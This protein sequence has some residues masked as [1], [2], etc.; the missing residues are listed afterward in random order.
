MM[1]PNTWFKC[2]VAAMRTGD[3]E[4]AITCFSTLLRLNPEFGE[5]WSNLAGVLMKVGKMR[6]AFE[7]ARQSIRFLR[8]NWRVWD[9]YVTI[10]VG[11]PRASLSQMARGELAA[12]IE[13]LATMLS[14]THKNEAPLDYALLDRLTRA[15]LAWKAPQTRL[16]AS[17]AGDAASSADTVEEEAVALSPV[18]LG[19]LEELET[20]EQE[21]DRKQAEKESG[22]P[23]A[24][25]ETGETAGTRE[26]LVKK[27]SEL[28]DDLQKRVGARKGGER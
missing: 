5:G 17:P 21:E 28:F 10:S 25:R 20:I 3:F 16:D 8:E 12:V 1:Y 27:L 11:S 7:A 4:S 22:E 15:V 2:G 24:T 6:E 18:V 19:E 14:L 13:G 26:F 23:G 9:N